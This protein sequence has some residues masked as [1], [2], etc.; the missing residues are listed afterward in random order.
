MSDNKKPQYQ[1]WN[2]EEFSGD[3][4]VQ[5]MTAVQR[6][7]Y[8][9]LLQKSFF[10]ST[11]PYLPNDDAMLWRLAGCENR[12]QWDENKSEVMERFSETE[13][14]GVTL[15]ENK[16]VTADWQRLQDKREKMSELGSRGAA[17]VQR[18]EG[19]KFSK[20]GVPVL[21]PTGAQPAHA[22][23]S[24]ANSEK[25]TDG[26]PAEVEIEIEAVKERESKSQGSNTPSAQS[27]GE[28]KTLPN[29]HNM[30]TR[31]KRLLGK[32]VSSPTRHKQTYYEMCELFS[33]EIVLECFD[34]WAPSKRE[35]ADD[36]KSQPIF[37]FWKN[38]PDLAADAIADLAAENDEKAAVEK[39]QVV[40]KQQ[41]AN[42]EASQRRQAAE[43][44][45]TLTTAPEPTIGECDVL[46]LLPELT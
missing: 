23:T 31:H 20:S 36:P 13:I 30:S 46:S 28:T 27:L 34:N 45:K 14:E 43:N 40:E 35:W 7:M 32:P 18:T 33:E 17:A 15:F 12:K 26:Q 39:A 21:I 11:R 25:H 9:T 6:W 5:S 41:A 8:R 42:V 10:Y 24:T 4:F 16:R 3:V 38:L 37:A 19:G 2:E 1:P 29:W 44:W 22:G